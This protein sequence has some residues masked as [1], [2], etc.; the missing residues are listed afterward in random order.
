MEKNIKL[1]IV[2]KNKFISNDFSKIDFTKNNTIYTY[3]KPELVT[4]QSL[5]AKYLKYLALIILIIF[6][7]FYFSKST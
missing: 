1:N 7:Y 3:P 4:F 6:I 5:L 2:K